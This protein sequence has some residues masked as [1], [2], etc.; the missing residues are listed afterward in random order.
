[1]MNRET[2]LP[3]PFCG[4]EAVFRE[5]HRN[6]WRTECQQCELAHPTWVVRQIDPKPALIAAWNTRATASSLAQPCSPTPTD[7]VVK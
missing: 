1:M 4:G 6:H 5:G 3:C 2:L 7:E